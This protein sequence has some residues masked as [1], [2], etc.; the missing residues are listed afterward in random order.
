M[1]RLGFIYL[2]LVIS[3]MTLP[4][5]GAS[6]FCNPLNID[7]RFATTPGPSHRTAA[8]PVIVTYLG[9]YYLFASK[10]GGYWWSSDFQNWHFVEPKTNIEIEKYAPAVMVTG[11]TMVYTPSQLGDLSVS[12]DPKRGQWQRIGH[13]WE[14]PQRRSGLCV[15]FGQL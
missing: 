12:T 10:S 2:W 13:P 7:Y 15:C 9:D 6:T 3:M 5:L 4:V 11:D 14:Q 1:R 8:D